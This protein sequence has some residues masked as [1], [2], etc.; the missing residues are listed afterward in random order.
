MTKAKQVIRILVADDHAIF[1]EGLRKLLDAA[2]EIQIVG[3]A[4]TGGERTRSGANNNRTPLLCLCAARNPPGN[5]PPR[6]NPTENSP[7][8][9]WLAGSVPPARVRVICHSPPF[10]R[11]SLTA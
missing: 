4:S 2:A 3:E 9:F 7:Q 1:R 11:S 8:V 5:F 6:G 10:D